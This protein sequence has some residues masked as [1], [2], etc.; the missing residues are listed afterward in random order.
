MA[1]SG[2]GKNGQMRHRS[3]HGG[4]GGGGGG[5]GSGY[6]K[7]REEKE[8]ENMMRKAKRKREGIY[9]MEGNKNGILGEL[10]L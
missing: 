9:R 3:I 10:K 4:G 6:W 1:H 8:I 5:G 7:N 2:A